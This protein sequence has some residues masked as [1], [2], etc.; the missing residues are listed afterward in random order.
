MA[1]L[2]RR[3]VEEKSFH[4]QL[5]GLAQSDPNYAFYTS[6]RKFYSITRASQAFVRGWLR[7]RCAGK[8]V[9]DYGCGDAHP[10]FFCAEHGAETVGIDV[11]EIS[12]QNA[13]AEA[14]RKGIA[15][16]TRFLVADCEA[17]GFKD[18]QFDLICVSGVLHHLDLRRAFAEMARVLRP[19]GEVICS[20]PL[21]HNPIFS[22]YRKMTPHLR[23]AWETEHLITRHDLTLVGEYFDHVEAR[24][25]H[26]ATLAAVPFRSCLGFKHLPGVLESIDSVVLTLPVVKW[27][28]WQVVF[29]LGGPR[30]VS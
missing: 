1:E 18:S 9:L 30:K 21:A 2:E 23:T 26:L 8:R 14:V 16:H 10:S 12:V 19:R 25:F 17:T 3:K 29:T 28:A 11:S 24:C 15:D 22:L 7:Q 13:K 5:M 27:L 4:D 20:E 6:N